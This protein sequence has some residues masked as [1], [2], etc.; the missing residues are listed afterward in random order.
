MAN[1]KYCGQP[2]GW[3]VYEHG[4]CEKAHKA[5]GLKEYEMLPERAP[6]GSPAEMLQGPV[7]PA[8]PVTAGGVFWA[9]F[10]ALC[11]YGLLSGVI[12]AIISDLD[13]PHPTYTQPPY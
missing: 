10:F 3:L 12:G 9:V 11:L 13:R 4:A 1:C 6:A 5:A 8:R 7:G 2:A